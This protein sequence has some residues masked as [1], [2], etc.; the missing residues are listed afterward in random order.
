MKLINSWKRGFDAA[1]AARLYSNGERPG[2][3]LGAALFNGSNLISIGFNIYAKTH[4]S[5]HAKLFDKNIHAEHAA[6]IKRQHYDNGNNLI[7]YV[8]RENSEG[9]PICSKPCPS[10]QA[11]LALANVRRVRYIDERGQFTE[12]RI[13]GGSN[14]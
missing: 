9:S 4:P 1:K 6:V 11:I 14:A 5:V 13:E 12:M 10:C 8:Y 7:L 3:K 2:R